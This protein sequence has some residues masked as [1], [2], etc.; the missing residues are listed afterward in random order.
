MTYM[1]KAIQ[2]ESFANVR[3]MPNGDL[4]PDIKVTRWQPLHLKARLVS[5]RRALNLRL[6]YASPY[7]RANRRAVSSREH[8]QA[9]GEG[10]DVAQDLV[11][12]VAA[13]TLQVVVARLVHRQAERGDGLL[14]GFHQ[15]HVGVVD[16]VLLLHALAAVAPV[17]GPPVATSRA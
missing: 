4:L 8:G 14:A 6:M 13:H 11:A 12:H 1:A 15:R 17:L 7:R 3:A 5:L 10:P 9:I 16:G 2:T